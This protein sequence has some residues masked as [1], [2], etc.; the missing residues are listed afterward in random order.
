[1]NVL[2]SPRHQSIASVTRAPWIS[3]ILNAKDTGGTLM[4][5]KGTEIV[6]MDVNV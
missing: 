5:S 2:R 6:Q 1:M 4:Q 3:S